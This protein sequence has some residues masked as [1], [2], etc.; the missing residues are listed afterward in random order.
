M[1][2]SFLN[3]FAHQIVHIFS[4]LLNCVR[5]VATVDVIR[6]RRRLCGLIDRLEALAGRDE[7][8]FE[9]VEE[10]VFVVDVQVCAHF[11]AHVVENEVEL[12][13]VG[14]AAVAL[15]VGDALNM[16]TLRRFRHFSILAFQ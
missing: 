16:L 11:A 1:C 10:T 15:P 8:G 2:L 13:E 7:L 9:V 4:Q 14:S 3:L 12:A 5:L 6:L